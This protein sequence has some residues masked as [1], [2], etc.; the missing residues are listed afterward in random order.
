MDKDNIEVVIVDKQVFFRNGLCQALSEDKD[1]L[2]TGCH[3]DEL[4]SEVEAQQPNVV[5]LDVDYPGLRGLEICRSLAY[6]FPE[7]NVI[8]LTPEPTAEELV[9][10]IR[11]GAVA[12]LSK[13]VTLEQLTR[14]I[15][16]ANRGEYPVSD[17]LAT[18]PEAAEQILRQFQDIVLMRRPPQTTDSHLTFRETQI[19]NYI[20]SGKTN[21]QIAQILLISE[22]TVKN[23]VSNILRKLNADD[24]AHAVARALNNGWIRGE[25][26]VPLWERP[27]IGVR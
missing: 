25:K 19:L 1:L 4:M 3:P 18:T 9:E 20:A 24:R 2:I 17:I 11:S 21:K 6:H 5:L 15:R 7:I 23:H 12:Y 8:M 13:N 22:Q 14:T 27:A 16:L 10:V 26:D